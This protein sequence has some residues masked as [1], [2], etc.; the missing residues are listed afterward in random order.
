M[1]SFDSYYFSLLPYTKKKDLKSEI[2][3]VFHERC[4]EWPALAKIPAQLTL[5][6]IR[7]LKREV[8]EQAR[9]LDLELSTVA[10]AIVYF[11]KPVFVRVRACVRV[12]SRI[13]F[14]FLSD[15]RS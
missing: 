14:C 4:T 2:N 5:S 8:H 7:N 13:S 6:K 3:E 9:R 10:L 15:S 1:R 11:E 12:C